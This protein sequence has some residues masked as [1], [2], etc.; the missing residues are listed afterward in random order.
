MSGDNTVVHI[1][2]P[3]FYMVLSL[4]SLK[5]GQCGKT[6]TNTILRGVSRP[7]SFNGGIGQQALQ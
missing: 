1:V 2:L 5:K 6:S 3:L 4:V 7:Y